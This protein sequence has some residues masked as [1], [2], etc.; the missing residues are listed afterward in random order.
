MVWWIDLGVLGL[1]GFGGG[2]FCVWRSVVDHGVLS[3]VSVAVVV[4][5]L[6]VLVVLG[7]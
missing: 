3:V 6:L 2:R 7:A 4:V 1:I 5:A